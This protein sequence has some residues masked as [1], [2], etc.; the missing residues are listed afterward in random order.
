MKKYY[1]LLIIPVFIA[2]FHT[3]LSAQV[4]LT[5]AGK[6]YEGYTGDTELAVG[7]TVHW[8]EAVAVDDSNDVYIADAN[9]NVIRKINNRNG[10]IKTIVGTGFEAG[11]GLGGYSGDGGQATAAKL[12]Y[13]S[14]IAVDHSGVIYIADQRNNVIRKVDATGIIT[15]KAGT[16]FAGYSGDGGQATNAMLSHPTRISLDAVG[17]IYVADS[18]NNKI[19]KI[20][21]AGI[22]YTLAG[23]GGKGFSGDGGAAP[24]AKLFNPMD[25]AVDAAGNVFIAD[26]V[27]NRIR[28]VDPSGIISTYGG[29][30]IAGYSGDSAAATNANIYEPSGIAVD[31]AG[32][33]YFSDMANFRVRKID[34]SG[35]ITTVVGNGVHGYNGDNILAKNAQ[36]WFPEGL[37]LDAWGRLYLADKGNNRIRLITKTLGLNNVGNE[38]AGITVYPNPNNGNFTVNI[39]S[40]LDEE[41]QLVML[42]VTGI[43]VGEIHAA[44]NRQISFTTDNLPPGMYFLSARTE[45]ASLK[46]KVMVR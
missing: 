16:S 44:T 35:I 42:N 4:I 32:N 45:H 21:A 9:N 46:E 26:Y 24:M 12:Y 40:A 43:R 30:G 6:G 31:A 14:G 10:I 11:T 7:C 25:M 41:V 18:G 20:D 19:R 17:N 22:I 36:I 1:Y 34:A 28:K 8:P 29:I 2:L 13:P 5:V 39:H 23:S 15:T 38:V 27:N 3:H 37:A 33:V